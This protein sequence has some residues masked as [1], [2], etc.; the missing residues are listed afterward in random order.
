MLLLVSVAL[1]G[2]ACGGTN[3]PTGSAPPASSESTPAPQSDGPFEPMTYPPD[4]DAPCDQA[5]P[6][7]GD[8]A[9]Y[10]GSIRR[11]RAIDARTVEFELCAPDVA[12]PTRLAVTSSAIND[13]AWLESH[14]DPGRSGEQAIVTAVN[15]T[16][17]Y[18]LETWNRG[19]D[20]T[21]VRND[22]YWGDAAR[23]ERLIVRWRDDPAAPPG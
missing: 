4:R 19:S 1:V 11:I 18:R 15:G 3:Q 17:P 14:I 20:I 12:L 22:A 7:D 10:T 8:H 2:Q 21:L 16:G 13:T 9:A 5:Q 6:P 23:T